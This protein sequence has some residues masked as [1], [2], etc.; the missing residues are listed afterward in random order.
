MNPFLNMK[1]LPEKELVPGFN[2]QLVHMN[3]TTVGHV[4]ANQGAQLPEH[5]HLHEQVTNVISGELEM[6]IAGQTKTCRAGD[7]VAIPPHVP[8]SARAL[9]DCYLIDV[10]HPV[11]E[12]YK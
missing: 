5:H 10:F 11:R 4:R 2:A 9:T 6:T 7:V 8:H 12:D 1:D 3:G